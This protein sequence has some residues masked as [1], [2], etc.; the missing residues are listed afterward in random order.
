MLLQKS[1]RDSLGIRLKDNIVVIDEAHNLI[2]AIANLNAV[3][4]DLPQT[5]AAKR[6]LAGYHSRY[7]SRLTGKNAARIKQLQ[8]IVAALEQYLSKEISMSYS[9]S[10]Q[11]MRL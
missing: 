11:W 6:Q 4:L 10:L 8:Q 9:S 5:S 3:T 1:S 7:Q 2:E